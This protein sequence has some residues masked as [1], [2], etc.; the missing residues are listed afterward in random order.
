MGA[1]VPG[2]ESTREWKFYVWNFRSRERK[3]VGTNRIE[4]PPPPPPRFLL[5]QV[6]FIPLSLAYIWDPVFI[7]N[8]A[9]IEFEGVQ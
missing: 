9:V 2:N 7:W 4:A 3:Y 6:T 1:K 8:P 5:V